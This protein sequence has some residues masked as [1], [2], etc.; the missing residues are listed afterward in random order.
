ME[1][2]ILKPE[3]VFCFSGYLPQNR[4]ISGLEVALL[5]KACIE[6]GRTPDADMAEVM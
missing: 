2:F 1:D 3:P 5:H 6:E 4:H